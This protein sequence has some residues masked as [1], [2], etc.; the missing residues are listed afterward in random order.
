MKC[1]RCGCERFYIKDPY[2]EYEIFEFDA[3]EDKVVFD[4]DYNESDPPELEAGTQTFCAMCSWH[5]KFGVLLKTAC[6]N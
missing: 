4:R 3:G 5:D 2:D 1:P 6:N